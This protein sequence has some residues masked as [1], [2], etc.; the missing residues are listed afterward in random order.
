MDEFGE[1]PKKVPKLKKS[2]IIGIVIIVVVAVVIFSFKGSIFGFVAKE[3]TLECND[4]IDNDEDGL[5]DYSYDAAAGRITGDLDCTS[6][7]DDS[8]A[9]ECLGIAEE[10][11]GLDDDCDGFI[12]EGVCPYCG[13]SKI[14]AGEECDGTDL[15]GNECSDFENF[16]TGEL[17][18]KDCKFDTSGCSVVV[19]GNNIIDPGEE[20]DGSNWGVISGCTDFDYTS[21]TLKCVNC[22]FDKS[23]CSSTKPDRCNDYDGGKE[24]DELGWISGYLNDFFYNLTD[25]CISSEKLKEYYCDDE[26]RRSEYYYCSDFGDNETVYVCEDGVCVV[27]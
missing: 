6:I 10:C 21:G 22:K 3:K 13:D 5:I 20:C 12:D 14:D 16:N 17:K 24:Y 2:H 25:K 9:R 8:E 7:K 4:E 18:C 26:E 19:C 23:D 27:E 11:N 15:D 1:T